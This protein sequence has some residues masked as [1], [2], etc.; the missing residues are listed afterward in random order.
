MQL[1]KGFCFNMTFLA[2]RCPPCQDVI[3]VKSVISSCPASTRSR[4][5]VLL[6][7]Q[8]SGTASK[9]DFVF[10]FTLNTVEPALH[11]SRIECRFCFFYYHSH[12]CALCTSISERSIIKETKLHSTPLVC[13]AG[14]KLKQADLK[15]AAQ[16]QRTCRLLISLFFQKNIKK[17]IT[18]GNF[19]YW[20]QYQ[21]LSFIFEL[22]AI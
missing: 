14:L 20:C 10:Y 8:W 17:L 6:H 13:K 2:S 11:T 19:S 16:I 15:N 21:K 18:F 1:Q 4:Q 9:T 5:N 22:K 3:N 7:S 12:Q